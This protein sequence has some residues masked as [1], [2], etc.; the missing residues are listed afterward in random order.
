MCEHDNTIIYLNDEEIIR[1]QGRHHKLSVHSEFYFMGKKCIVVHKTE[2]LDTYIYAMTK[3]DYEK[4]H[5]CVFG[6]T[7][8]EIEEELNNLGLKITTV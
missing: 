2:H 3:E 6:Y 1:L 8:A 5:I 7:V 4:H